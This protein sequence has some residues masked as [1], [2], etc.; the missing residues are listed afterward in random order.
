[1]GEGTA[2]KIAGIRRAVERDTGE[3]TEEEGTEGETGRKQGREKGS[4]GE[5]EKL[6]RGIEEAEESGDSLLASVLLRKLKRL[7]KLQK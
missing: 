6:R 3:G 1:M 4:Q 7:T 2:E 5:K